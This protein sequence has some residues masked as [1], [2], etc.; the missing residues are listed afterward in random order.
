MGNTTNPI[1]LN[2]WAYAY[3]NPILYTDPSG[4]VP[5][6]MLPPEDQVNCVAVPPLPNWWK[7]RSH[8]YVD[9][10]GYFDAG[11]LSR[12]W[13]SAEYIQNKFI[14]VL[15]EGGE[16]FLSSS[17][18][19]PPIMLYWEKYYVS[20]QVKNLNKEL[21]MGVMYGIYTD[22]EIGYETYQLWNNLSKL[23]SA[24]SPE[25]LPSDHLG[26]WTSIHGLKEDDLPFLFTC[27]GEVTDLGSD[28]FTSLVIDYSSSPYGS[29]SWIP[30]NFK[31]QPMVTEQYS[32]PN[33]GVSGSYSENRSWPTWLQ[34]QPVP[35]GLD[36]WWKVDEGHK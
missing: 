14:D 28:K 26:F 36:T 13:I 18:G 16:I 31:F 21:Q 30:R 9:G 2:R 8:L 34:I 7:N 29:S 3:Q 19:D 22:F 5:C 23:P 6:H 24:F 11:H 12:G 4:N 20:S 10:Y 17:E 33:H 27:L 32:D 15:E 25:D 35:S 1:T